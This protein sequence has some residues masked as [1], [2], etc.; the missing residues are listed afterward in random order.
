LALAALAWPATAA[1]VDVLPGTPEE[2][3]PNRAEVQ[4]ALSAQVGN[5]VPARG[6]RLSYRSKAD[7]TAAGGAGR[8][9]VLHLELADERGQSRLRR[10]LRVEGGDCRAQADAIALIVYRFFAQLA[11]S[12]IEALAPAPLPSRLPRRLRLSLEAGAGVWTRR[13]GTGTSV[14]GF[15][16]A[17]ANLETAFSVL[18]PRATAA[19][20]PAD[21]GQVEVSALGMALS[22]GLVWQG[23]RLRLHGGPLFLVSRESARTSGIAVP[24]QNVGTTAALGLAAGASWWL[25][26]GVGLGFEAGLAHAVFGNRFVVG[27]WGPVLA[28]PP[29]QAVVLARLGYA[30]SP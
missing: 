5:G 6:W 17:W 8:R 13:P 16:L 4:K 15:R 11:G 3:C 27:G 7:S 21:A 26:G 14:F 2:A 12:D 18:A 22:V 20:R 29:W 25:A 1:P 30:F 24:A 28:P 9:A 10:Q 23:A 19:E